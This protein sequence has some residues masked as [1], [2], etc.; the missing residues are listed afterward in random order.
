[1]NFLQGII[2][3]IFRLEAGFER[4]LIQLHQLL[5]LLLLVLHID[6]ILVLSS[7]HFVLKIVK[8]D[9]HFILPKLIICSQ[10][11]LDFFLVDTFFLGLFLE[12]FFFLN[13]LEGFSFL[14]FEVG[15]WLFLSFLLGLFGGFL[16]L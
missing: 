11:A 4:S 7:L 6:L 15:F 8:S 10:N 12:L 14:G 1:M 3:F 5:V 9:P 13:D 2:V 16:F